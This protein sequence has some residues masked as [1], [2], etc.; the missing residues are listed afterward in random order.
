VPGWHAATETLRTEGRLQM[1][2]IV[3][4]QHPDRAR[5]FMQWK[6]MDWPI[7]VDSLNLLGVAAVPLTFAIDEHG[8][9]RLAGLRPDAVAELEAFLATDY[10]APPDVPARPAASGAA[11]EP[12]AEDA[13]ARRRH[14]D[15]RYLWG[16]APGVEAAIVGKPDRAF[17]D[18]ALAA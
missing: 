6:Q 13:A 2:G 10:A 11:G 4:E 3:Q 17:F 7:L 16:G 5:L 18:L 9:V 14:A 15:A 1:A 8:I 12:A